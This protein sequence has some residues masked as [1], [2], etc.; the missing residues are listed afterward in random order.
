MQRFQSASIGVTR[1]TPWLPWAQSLTETSTK[2]LQVSPLE[3]RRF[4]SGPGYTVQE[5]RDR[6]HEGLEDEIWRLL[7]ENVVEPAEDVDVAMLLG[8][9][10]PFHRGEVTPY[11]DRTGSS[12]KVRGATVQPQ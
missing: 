10:L 3:P 1:F 9:G 11:V 4:G 12:E 5:L 6:V 7:E 8:A 2:K